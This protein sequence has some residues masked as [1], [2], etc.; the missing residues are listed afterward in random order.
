MM[1]KIY[2]PVF[3]RGTLR[4]TLDGGVVGEGVEA[5]PLSVIGLISADGKLLGLDI[6]DPENRFLPEEMQADHENLKSEALRA[7]AEEQYLEWR[8]AHPPLPAPKGKPFNP[9]Y[10][11]IELSP[12]EWESFNATLESF[13]RPK[14]WSN[15][16][17]LP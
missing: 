13:R 8:E 4:L 15:P 6:Q 11:R 9:N 1:E 17:D 2:R 12:E 3:D 5:R 10:P 14:P 16:W 7:E